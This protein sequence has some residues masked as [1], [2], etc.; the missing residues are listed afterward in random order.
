MSF[1]FLFVAVLAIKSVF[2]INGIDAAGSVI[3][4]NDYECLK[5]DGY[6]FMS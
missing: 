1:G 6:T 4:V 5:K 3:S 2:G